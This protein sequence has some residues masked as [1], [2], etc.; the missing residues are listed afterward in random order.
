VGLRAAGQSCEV[1]DLAPAVLV[2]VW[3][4]GPDWIGHRHGTLGPEYRTEIE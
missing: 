4:D 1:D 2:F 3:L